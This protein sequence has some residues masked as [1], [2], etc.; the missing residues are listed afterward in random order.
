MFVF[1]FRIAIL[2]TVCQSSVSNQPPRNHDGKLETMLFRK[3]QRVDNDP[4]IIISSFLSQ[5]MRP[6]VS[7]KSNMLIGPIFD[8]VAKHPSPYNVEFAHSVWLYI[9]RDIHSV[10]PSQVIY[11][12]IMK[13]YVSPFRRNHGRNHV[14]HNEP[15]GAMFNVQRA[16]AAVHRWAHE[17]K[18]DRVGLLVWSFTNVG[19]DCF[20]QNVSG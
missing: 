9:N 18:I 6:E 14:S 12:K 20:Y 10:K 4:D 15:D 17:Y 3:W 5:V 16:A 8:L 11:S 2:V 13:V 19:N 1:Y 7:L